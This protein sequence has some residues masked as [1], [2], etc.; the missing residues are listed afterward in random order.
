[1]VSSNQSEALATPKELTYIEIDRLKVSPFQSRQHISEKELEDLKNAI[2]VQGVLQPLLVRKAGDVFEVVAG[3]R[4]LKASKALGLKELPVLIKDIDDR[5]AL[6]L[7]IMENLQREDLNP[8]EEAM[9]FNR[10][11]EDFDFSHEEIAEKLGKD[12]STITN[13]LRLL[14]LPS[15]IQDALVS[16]RITKSQ[17]RTLLG[18]KE[19]KAM[20]GMFEQILRSNL[21][22]N[23][24]E[25]K[26]RVIKNKSRDIYL[27]NVEN[28]LQQ[29]LGRK[30]KITAKG[31]K[32]RIII[33]YYSQEDLEDLMALLGWQEG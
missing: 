21:P 7:S 15:R 19:E 6:I 3:S 1:V 11:A 8:V 14:N 9:S 30:V 26:V 4:R 10:L 32:G 29:K 23:E 20:L 22:V 12:R 31:K 16:K 13:A 25:K 28:G 17:A 33:E 18:I 27:E 2:K 5:Q 24:L